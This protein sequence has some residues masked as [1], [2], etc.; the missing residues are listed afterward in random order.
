MTKTKTIWR[1][2]TGCAK[3]KRPCP[4]HNLTLIG[5]IALDAER[6]GKIEGE[7]FDDLETAEGVY[8]DAKPEIE[9][10]VLIDDG[11]C[12]Y[13]FAQVLTLEEVTLT[14]D[15]NG[16]EVGEKSKVLASASWGV[17]DIDY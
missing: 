3:V 2:S 16:D 10:P 6:E 14:L 9:S 7:S 15:E 4:V 12:V 8:M 11:E 5:I 1:V 17:E 13:Y